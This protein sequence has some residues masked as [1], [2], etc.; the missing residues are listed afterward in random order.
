MSFHRRDSQAEHE[1]G[2]TVRRAAAERGQYR[3]LWGP[4]GG[5]AGGVKETV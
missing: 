3:A 2:T 5:E 1:N 4:W